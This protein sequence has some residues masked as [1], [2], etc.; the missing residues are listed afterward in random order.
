MFNTLATRKVAL[1]VAI[2]FV[3]LI[4]LLGTS[5]VAVVPSQS[6]DA[7][8]GRMELYCAEYRVTVTARGDLVRV[9]WVC[10]DW[11][12]RWRGGSGPRLQ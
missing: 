2:V 1:K 5:L 7:M 10:I 9:S 8:S 11:Q 12:Y 6:A 3:A 4:A